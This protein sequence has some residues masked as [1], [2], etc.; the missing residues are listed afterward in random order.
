MERTMLV[1]TV[2]CAALI[3]C[4]EGLLHSQSSERPGATSVLPGFSS[5]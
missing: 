1:I 3:S 4:E 5:G 2:V